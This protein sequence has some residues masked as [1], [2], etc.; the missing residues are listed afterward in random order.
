MLK[1]TILIATVFSCTA[2]FNLFGITLKSDIVDAL[3]N[4]PVVQERLRNFRATQQDLGIAEAEYYPSIDVRASVG[5]TDAGSINSEVTDV[6]YTNYETSIKLTQNIFDGFSTTSKVDYEEDRIL[7]AAYNYV[8][9]SNDIAFKMAN[10]YINVLKAHELLEISIENVKITENIY[11]KVKDLFAAGMSTDS[12]VKKIQSALALAR[13]NL[14]VQKNNTKDIEYNYRR[15]L[16]RLPE[17][18]QMEKPSFNL[19][20]PESIE[21]AAMYAIEHNPS[22]LVSRYNIRGSQALWKQ[23]KKDFYPRIDL[24]VTQNYNDVSVL[25]NGFNQPDD[26]FTARLVLNYN[27][28]R[29]GADRAKVQKQISKINQEIAIKRDLKRQVIEGLDLSWNAYS[30]IGL[31][32][33]DLKKYRQYSVTTLRLYEE[34]YDLGRR[35]LLDLLSAQNDVISSKNQIVNAKYDYLFAKYRILDAMGLLVEA[36][37]GDSKQFSSKVN[38]DNEN[39]KEVLDTIPVILDVDNDNITD[40]L[41][42]CDNS[43][44]ENNIMPYGCKKVGFDSDKDGIIDSNDIC[45]LTPLS[46][47]VDANGCGL[48][49]DND[50]IK[51]YEDK[52]L[53]TPSGYEVDTFG[54]AVSVTLQINFKRNSVDIPY[55]ADKDIQELVDFLKRKKDY[56]I[57]VIG[58]TN[59]R[60]SEAYNLELSKKRAK[61]IRDVIIEN[62]I[63]SS[64]IA[65]EGRGESDPLYDN[66]TEEGFNANRRVEIKL[67]KIDKGM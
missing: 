23:S 45:P 46:V 29:G 39:A 12:E 1:K 62:G 58:H 35:S 15:I 43:L 31:Q 60:G 38:L 56:K 32:L 66:S 52:C 22:L 59:S 47:K 10:A 21:R 57:V 41:D 3:H 19:A 36:V 40:D 54:C 53:D 51:D 17:Y 55:S 27:I 6:E 50:G 24:E 5:Y 2:S 48:D 14:I 42:L 20:M 7:A 44:K 61:A 11:K 67:I 37:V 13:S 25:N 8:E 33:K 4:N 64:R 65:Y 30:M 18:A 28:F 26:R 16:G 49:L 63:S 34:E 9:K